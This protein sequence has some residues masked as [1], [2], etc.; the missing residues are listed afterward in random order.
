MLEA[1]GVNVTAFFASDVSSR[2]QFL[3]N[4]LNIKLTIEQ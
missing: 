2:M 4:A 1:A 3:I